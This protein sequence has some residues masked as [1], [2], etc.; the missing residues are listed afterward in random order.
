M[1]V[2]RWSRRAAI[3]SLLLVT[4]AASFASSADDLLRAY[5]GVLAG[6]DGIDLIWRD[7]SRMP[8]DDGHPDKRMEEQLRHGSILDQMRLP[9]PSGE[10]L[11]SAPQQ[12]PGRVRNAAFFDKIYGDCRKGQVTPRLV[13][14]V[15]LP[16]TWGHVVYITSVNEVD[17]KL[18]AISHELDELS[19]DEDLYPVGGTYVCRQVADTGQS[20]HARLGRGHRYQ[21]S[22]ADYWLWHRAAAATQHTSELHPF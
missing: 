5:P 21:P 19:A 18:S 15:W 13:P 10:P 14:L 9:Y 6:F 7:G 22:S 20:E 17:R 2:G 3:T 8:V 4:S 11:P 1:T 12:D 16:N